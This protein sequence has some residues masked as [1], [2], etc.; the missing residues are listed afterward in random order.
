MDKKSII[1]GLRDFGQSASNT[2]AE[3]V[4]MPVDLI[5][6]G[7]RYGGLPIPSDPVGG[8]EWM[9]KR[10]LT[11]DVDPGIAKT[12][13]EAAGMI[14][15]MVGAAK[16]PQIA[17]G[18]N[19]MARNAAIP[20]TMN[21]QAGAIV[22]HGSPHKFDKFD[23]SKIGTGEGAQAYGHGIYLAE[24]PGVATGY[25]DKLSNAV[26]DG[27]PAD[28]YNS[29]QAEEILRR[30]KPRQSLRGPMPPE[31]ST[32]DEAINASIKERL[33]NINASLGRDDLIYKNNTE[34]EY[35]KSFLGKN[36]ERG[37]ALYKVDLPD[38]QI[39][40]MLD[41]DKPMSQQSAAVRKSWQDSKK[42]LPPNAMDDLGGDLSLMYGKDVRPQDFLNTWESLGQKAGGEM[43]LKQAGI[44]GIRYLDG[45]SRGAGSGTSNFVVFPG[46]ED[47]LKILERNGNG[48]GK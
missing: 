41:W 6:A 40:K 32:L 30:M 19:Q 18:M 1:K 4:S 35:L 39:A 43:A 33:N 27:I 26:I 10:G 28:L 45:G 16:A 25:R 7:L 44:P 47:I 36:I 20:A 42:L 17:A 29:S 8:S 3:T 24:S 38:D 2:V 31:A 14:V 11:V 23:S 22:W 12:A 9:K 13:G 37:G 34:I 21:K 15:P 5:A 46:N 48:I